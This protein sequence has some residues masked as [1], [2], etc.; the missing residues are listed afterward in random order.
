MKLPSGKWILLLLSA[1]SELNRSPSRSIRA[2]ELAFACTPEKAPHD[3]ADIDGDR[4]TL[5]GEENDL[6]FPVI[7][8][9]NRHDDALRYLKIFRNAFRGE[10]DPGMDFPCRS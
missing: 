9:P 1:N 7:V 5:I 8:S 10:I 4:L 2:T 3:G 6:R